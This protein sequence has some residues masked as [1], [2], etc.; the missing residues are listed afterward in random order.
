MAN[1]RVYR[2]TNHYERCRQ[3]TLFRSASISVSPNG[4]TIA[5]VVDD[6]ITFAVEDPRGVWSEKPPG[7]PSRDTPG[8]QLIVTGSGDRTAMVWCT[9]A[10][11]YG[12]HRLF[13]PDGTKIVT[14]S[15]DRTAMA[16]D[17]LED[18]TGCVR[19]ATFSPD[20]TK[21]VTGSTDTT[22]R[23]WD[24]ETGVRLCTLGNYTPRIVTAA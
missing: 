6:T 10:Y 20:G 23:V 11:P 24:A 16:W 15:C 19:T 17:A 1:P 4:K 13:S 14:G 7:V 2:F 5:V 22:A 21:I 3:I 9:A 8:S 18:H 12:S